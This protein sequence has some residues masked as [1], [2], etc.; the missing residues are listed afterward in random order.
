VQRFASVIRLRP[1]REAE[2]IELHAAVWP[3]VLDAL[4][5][6]NVTNYS[7]FYRDGLLFSYLEYT[8]LDYDADTKRIAADEATRRWWELTDPCQEPLA[9]ADD[10]QLWAP[11][12]ELFHMD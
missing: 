8:G 6:A 2:Y 11:A 1:E 5:A 4:R 10:G 12:E 9:T 7:I 3:A